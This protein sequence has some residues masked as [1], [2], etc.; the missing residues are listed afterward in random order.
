VAIVLERSTEGS[1]P[2]SVAEARAFARVTSTTEDSIVEDLIAAARRYAE[3]VSG[4]T[5]TSSA[6]TWK[7]YLDDF[8][9][10]DILLP[11][12]PVTAVS[13]ISYEDED[14]S[15]QT[16]SSANYQT[17]FKSEP[18]RVCYV[19]D[20]SYPVTQAATFN[21]VTVTYTAGY[22]TVPADYI[23]GI[24]MLVNHWF[25]VRRP[26]AERSLIPVPVN[27]TSLLRR[28]RVWGYP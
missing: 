12:P 25:E 13:S 11:R 5:L 21:V 4:R 17:D 14:G 22:T 28:N 18:A 1:D 27:I 3:D 24:K 8:P 10:G 16:W 15:T 9:D 26:V 2:V 19:E 6:S 7:L 20:G 23:L